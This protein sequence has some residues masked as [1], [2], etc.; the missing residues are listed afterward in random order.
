[1]V[2]GDRIGPYQ[3][4]AQL[5]IGGMGEVFRATDTRLDR[6]VA[7]KFSHK[8]FSRSLLREARL[9]CTVKHR[10]ICQLLDVGEHA[11]ECYLVLEFV[12]GEPLSDRLARGAIPLQVAVDLTLEV[13]GAV[14]AMHGRGLVHGDLKPANIMLTPDGLRILDFGLARLCSSAGAPP[15]V[16][17]ELSTLAEG[18]VHGTPGYM[19]PEQVR[20]E[21][22]TPLSDLFAVG[23]ILFEML[24]GAPAFPGRTAGSRLAAVLQDS[25]A[26]LTGSAVPDA[27]DAIIRRSLAKTP[28]ARF[29]SA[30]EFAEGLR[31]AVEAPSVSDNV[32]AP[33]RM[34]VLPFRALRHDPE[35]EFLAQSLPEAITNELAGM[36]LLQ[37]RSSLVGNRYGAMPTDLKAIAAE[38]DVNIVVTGTFLRAGHEMRVSTQMMQV[39]SGTILGVSTFRS[40]ADD[41]FA[42]QDQAVREIVNALE[43]KSGVKQVHANKNVP[44]MGSAYQLYLRAN[45]ISQDRRRIP[46]ARSL[47]EQCLAVDPNYA[48]AWA[49]L[50][51][52]YR[53]IAKYNENPAENLPLAQEALD[54]ALALEPE[55]DL[56][57]S[58]YAQLETDLGRPVNALVRLLRLA[59]EKRHSA[60]VFSGLVYACR[61][62]GLLEE[63]V[64]SHRKARRLDPTVGTSVTHTYFQQQDYLHCLET[65]SGDIGYIDALALVGLGHEDEALARV[66]DRLRG[67]NSA[68]HAR[69]YLESLWALL[70]GDSDTSRRHIQTATSEYFVGPEELF[71]LAR[72]TVRLGDVGPGLA[73]IQRAVHG[74][75]SVATALTT[76]P[77]LRTIRESPEFCEVVA[78]ARENC[79]KAR[80]IFETSGGPTLLR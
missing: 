53:L 72:Q 35:T 79:R 28:A 76:D 15:D 12:E 42:I 22:A 38:A 23:A 66:E 14:S 37:V 68:R 59:R 65:Y 25:P 57:Q 30:S 50:G 55:L 39:P 73:M 34:L 6:P 80:Q 61:F 32:A 17:Q 16:T 36:P 31:A 21:A 7:L 1:M 49:R 11:G 24:S 54:R 26:S 5:G 13:L 77:W 10:S 56:A 71:Y 64:Q 62:C 47:Y 3:V 44:Q 78:I 45:L 18:G 33:T 4:T 51:R 46:E 2:I 43:A 40:R 63:S 9:A 60:E 52:C 19:S 70:S 67:G 20:G 27:I 69:L 48:P 58:Y 8:P 41:L 74:G 29:A 75:Y